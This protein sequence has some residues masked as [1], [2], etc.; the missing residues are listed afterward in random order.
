MTVLHHEYRDA[1]SSRIVPVPVIIVPWW[2]R[3]WLLPLL[4]LLVLLLRWLVLP[5]YGVEFPV[6]SPMVPVIEAPLLPQDHHA[7][8][9]AVRIP[10]GG[11][12]SPRGEPSGAPT[13][14]DA[15]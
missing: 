7:A 1:M 13:R 11:A 4:L 14:G 15:S 6:W 2:R 9:P 10:D 5:H 12:G 3:F 8:A